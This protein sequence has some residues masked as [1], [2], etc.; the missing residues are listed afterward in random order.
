MD[1]YR[2]NT[3]ANLTPETNAV[4]RVLG[5]FGRLWKTGSAWDTGTPLSKEAFV[6]DRQHQSYAVIA[7]LGPLAGPYRTG[8][9]AVTSITSAPDGAPATTVGDAVPADAPAGSALGAGA[10]DSALGRVAELV[11]TVRGPTPP[12]TRPSTPTSTRGPGG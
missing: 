11:D 6:H 7:G 4:V 9:K 3:L 10:H 8:A 12:A 5:G 1:D 2:T